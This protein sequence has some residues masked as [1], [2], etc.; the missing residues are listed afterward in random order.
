MLLNKEKIIKI[1]QK[2]Y[3]LLEVSTAHG[4]PNIVRAKNVIIL[5]M[6][7]IITSLSTCAGLYFVINDIINFLKY[8]TVTVLEAVNEQHSQFPTISICGYPPLNTSIDKLLLKLRFDRIDETNLSKIFEEFN[9][10]IFGKCCLWRCLG[11]T[12]MSKSSITNGNL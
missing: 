1:K 6:W 4:L 7:S 8:D 2:T 3:S 11:K 10:N 5:I 9:D 12:N